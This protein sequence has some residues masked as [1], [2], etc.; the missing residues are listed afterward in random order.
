MTFWKLLHVPCILH[1]VKPLSIKIFGVRRNLFGDLERRRQ[2]I[3][4]SGS[5]LYDD[6]SGTIQ[7]TKISKEA[8]NEATENL[9]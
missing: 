4:S 6:R 2:Y 9:V 8:Y 3:F 7:S 1:S 5:L